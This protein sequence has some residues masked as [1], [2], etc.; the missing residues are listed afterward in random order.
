MA[1]SGEQ[2]F[3]LKTTMPTLLA[4]ATFSERAPV[5]SAAAKALSSHLKAA[6]VA[7]TC[8]TEFRKKASAETMLQQL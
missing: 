6:S 3:V 2:S 7:P 8:V 4:A 5:S 1:L